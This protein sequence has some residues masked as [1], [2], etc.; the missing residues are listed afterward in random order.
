MLQQHAS[1]V[2]MKRTAFALRSA[3][4]KKMWAAKCDV[5]DW[6]VETWDFTGML[7]GVKSASEALVG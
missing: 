3:L 6:D 5:G 1:T 2:A 7:L 4:V